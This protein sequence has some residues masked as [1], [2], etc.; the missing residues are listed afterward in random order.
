MSAMKVALSLENIREANQFIDPVFLR[1]PQF[2]SAELGKTTTQS[3]LSSKLWGTLS[4]M[5]RISFRTA[6]EFLRRSSSF[7]SSFAHP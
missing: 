5:F 4:G 3:A 2:V 7:A 6:P 1:S